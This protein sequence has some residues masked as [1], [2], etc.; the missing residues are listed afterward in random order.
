MSKLKFL[1]K[2]QH[3]NLRNRQL[4]QQLEIVRYLAKSETGRSIPEM[5]KY[6]KSSVP[7]L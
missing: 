7:T 3:G 5:A 4:N 6:I 1:S 2:Y